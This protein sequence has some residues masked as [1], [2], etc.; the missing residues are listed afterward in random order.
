MRPRFGSL[1]TTRHATL[2]DS[3]SETKPATK[4]VPYSNLTVGVVKEIYPDE[5]RVAIT[6]QNTTL[7]LKKGF[8]KVLIERG[9]GIEAQFTDA[10]YEK[11][12]ATML[13]SKAVC[14]VDFSYLDFWHSKFLGRQAQQTCLRSNSEYPS[15]T[16]NC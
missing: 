7:L 13:D 8:S 6:P 1:T 15:K 3:P 11:A 9:A 2:K 12:G 4:S 16:D 14:M 5:K 10:A